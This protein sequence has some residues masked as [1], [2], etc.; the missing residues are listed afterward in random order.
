MR[1]L[2]IAAVLAAF[3]CA[4]SLTPVWAQSTTP[5][6]PTPTPPNPGAAPAAPGA[7]KAAAAAASAP[8]ATAAP[9]DPV[10]AKVG[11]QVIHQSDVR[12]A[13][14]GVPEQYR[15]LPP[16]MLFP[17]L[18]DQLI[19]RKAVAV[20]AEKEGLENDPAVK[21]SMEKAAQAALENAAVA[22]AVRPQISDAAIKAKYD[23]EYGNKPGE[24]EVHARHILV[25]TQDEA[26][27]IIDQ[28]N[29][30]ADFATLAKADS[31]DKAAAAQG[32]DLGWFKK[33]DMLPEFSAAAF[34]LQPGQISQAPVHTRYG[35][36]VIKV[37]GRRTTPPPSFDEAKQEIRQTLIQQAVQNFVAEAK[38][39]VHIVKFN[40]DGSVPK[41]ADTAVPPAAAAPPK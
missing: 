20:Y 9:A 22:R 11:D 23:Q 40:M 24:E 34:A 28:L 3:S 5:T 12:E 13:L 26:Q 16:Q 21:A 32:G 6:A 25:K 10:V 36:H 14:S 35:W 38:A 31:T 41:P 15:E 1:T 19:D 7:P 27:K 33:G 37:E 39:G 17:M 8:A 2:R 4:T 29:K 30:G 18:L